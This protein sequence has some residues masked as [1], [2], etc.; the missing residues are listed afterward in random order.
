MNLLWLRNINKEGMAML[1]IKY[2]KNAWKKT[3]VARIKEYGS[4]QGIIGFGIIEREQ[5]YIQMKSQPKNEKYANGSVGAIVGLMVRG[6]C[7]PVRS[8]KEMDWK[9]NDDLSVCGTKETEIHMF[10]LV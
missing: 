5:Q 3:L 2:D 6:G 8:S 10:F 4:R 1:R 9:Y 7:H